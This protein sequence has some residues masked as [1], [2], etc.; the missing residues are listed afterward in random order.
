[1]SALHHSRLMAA[2]DRAAAL[3]EYVASGNEAGVIALLS[4]GPSNLY[5]DIGDV[6][7]RDS[8]FSWRA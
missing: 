4:D 1:M 5:L 8:R 3:R 6:E 7:G 2:R